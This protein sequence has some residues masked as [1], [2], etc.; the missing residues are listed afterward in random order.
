V[1]WSF[2]TQ[3]NLAL[4]LGDST[5][6]SSSPPARLVVSLI[7]F[8]YFHSFHA[9][10]LDCGPCEDRKF[11]IRGQHEFPLS[12]VRFNAGPTQ[13]GHVD[14][15]LSP[16]E[17]Y[18][19]TLPKQATLQRDQPVWTSVLSMLCSPKVGVLKR[20]VPKGQAR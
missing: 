17:R 9:F 15:A 20:S 12:G 5:T 4:V 2:F 1:L 13:S 7:Y 11:P 3:I 6:N 18:V 16:T 14:N 10:E 19:E 8:F